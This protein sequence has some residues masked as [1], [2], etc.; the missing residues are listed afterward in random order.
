[1]R[2]NKGLARILAPAGNPPRRPGPG[3]YPPDFTKR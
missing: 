3:G 2:M 1:L